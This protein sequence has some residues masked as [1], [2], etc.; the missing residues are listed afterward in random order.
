MHLAQRAYVLIFLAAVLAVAQ[1]WTSEVDVP[2]L[3]HIPAALLLMGLA[4]EAL[5]VRRLL[6]G[7][8][9]ETA[10]RAFLG[11]PQPAAFVFANPASR[12]IVIEYQP[13]LPVGFEPLAQTRKVT[14]PPQGAGRDFLT[15]LPV[16]LGR[17]SWPNLPARIL[18]PLGFAWWDRE[19][20]LSTQLAIAPDVAGIPRIRPRGNPG[21]ARQRR[22]TG[23]GS[24]LH[25]LRGYV[26]GDPLT[27]IDWK[28]TARSRTLVTREYSE[29]QH[30]DILVAVDAGR[31]SRIRAGRLDR[32]GT[33]ANI[34]ARFAEVVTPNDDRVGLLVFSDRPLAVC[35]PD[36][37]LPAVM[38]IRKALEQLALDAA[39]SDATQAAVGIR[40][41]LKHRGLV[42]LLTDLDD[43]AAGDSLVRAV[44][45]LSPPHFVVVA[46]V[47][48]PE[49]AALGR[50]EALAWNDPWV[51][52]AAREYE[53][54]ANA[55][56]AQL[57][58][59]GASVIE[60]REEVLERAVIAEYEALRRARRV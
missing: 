11:R 45:L 2:R 60:A 17:Q 22:T 46:G 32:F 3:W 19:L 20:P 27:R 34:A 14:A 53:V 18:G 33:Y 52:L 41:L 57:R 49:I 55:H 21:G 16:R 59:L 51:A 13:L 12:P 50:Q 9:V 31:F 56:R 54:R 35:A 30:L 38:R 43:F 6:I 23:A 58:R 28:A 26:S 29:D 10:S 36:R 44:R 40:R 39:E 37:G 42:V 25:Q 48:S 47:Q 1:V 15:L 24:E 5:F 8:E 7:A 4:L